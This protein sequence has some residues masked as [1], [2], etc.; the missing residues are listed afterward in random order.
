MKTKPE[1]LPRAVIV[2]AENDDKHIIEIEDYKTC[3]V[4]PPSEGDYLWVSTSGSLE[5]KAF[6]LRS[7]YDWKIVKDDQG[8]VCLI[9][10]KK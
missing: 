5:G 9:P 7:V 6:F 8:S 1:Q 10:L 2:K 3:L 4:T